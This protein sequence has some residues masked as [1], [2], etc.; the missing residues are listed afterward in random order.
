M[1]RQTLLAKGLLVGWCFYEKHAKKFNLR[2]FF[3]HHP[4]RCSLFSAYHNHKK[5][6]ILILLQLF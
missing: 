2:V 6:F 4:L 3:C 5:K 1:D